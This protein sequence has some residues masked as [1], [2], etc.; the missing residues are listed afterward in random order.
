MKRVSQLAAAVALATASLAA[1]AADI[2]VSY[3]VNYGDTLSTST[4]TTS[5]FDGGFFNVN[6][7]M[8]GGN[9]LEY[10]LHLTNGKS[11]AAYCIDP[12]LGNGGNG[13]SYNLSTQALDSIARLF[14]VAG[15]NGKGF[16]TDGVNTGVKATALALAIWEVTYDGLSS[17]VYNATDL[18]LSSTDND[19][20]ASWLNMSTGGSFRAGGFSYDA[21]SQAAAYLNGAKGL[22][23]GSYVPTVQVLVPTEAGYQRMVTSVP[24]PSTYALLA[25]CLGVVGFAT[26]RKMS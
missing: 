19:G 24:E 21:V 12:L 17:S 2:K 7:T 26:R 13:A 25:A 23:V 1:S 10:Q 18:N 11:F 4:S 20:T 22:A 5:G 9:A 6:G 15:F 8:G 16:A 14:S 3:S